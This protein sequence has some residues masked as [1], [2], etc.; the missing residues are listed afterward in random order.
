MV[1]NAVVINPVLKSPTILHAGVYATNVKTFK[2]E[3][4]CS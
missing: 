2:K 3:N 4:L 1:F